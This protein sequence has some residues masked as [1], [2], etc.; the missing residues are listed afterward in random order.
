MISTAHRPARPSAALPATAPPGGAASEAGTGSRRL[1]V[2]SAV[3][4][5]VVAFLVLTVVGGV[6]AL[7]QLSSSSAAGV[8]HQGPAAPVLT[9]DY[10]S[11]TVGSVG[12]ST[13]PPAGA[14]PHAAHGAAKDSGQPARLHV[15]V[16]MTNDGASSVGYAPGQFRLVAGTGQAMA[17]ED[18]PLL[19]GRLRPGAAVTLR[20]TFA[21]PS[22]TTAARLV[23][24][25]ASPTDGVALDL[26]AATAVDAPPAQEPLVPSM[27]DGKSAGTEDH[28]HDSHDH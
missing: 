23:I 17:A 16:T 15:P 21:V 7:L 6:L 1:A 20:L 13:A 18:G 9:T 2:R 25:G 24:S 3:L 26:P 11:V 27:Q 5:V 14:S 28:S 8:L 4:A 22:G 12:R 19:E 10:G